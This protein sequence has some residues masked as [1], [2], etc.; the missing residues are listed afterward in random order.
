MGCASPAT[1]GT[2]Q[3]AQALTQL[4][5]AVATLGDSVN[6]HAAATEQ[7]AAAAA[8]LNDQ[9]QQLSALVSRFRVDST[10]D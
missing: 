9:A 4:G 10:P 1:E 5:I 8:A 2:T 7:N 6:Q 3:Q